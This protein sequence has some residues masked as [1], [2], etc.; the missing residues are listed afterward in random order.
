MVSFPHGCGF[1]IRY[2]RTGCSSSEIKT[3][4]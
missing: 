4:G 1:Y 2:I 3:T